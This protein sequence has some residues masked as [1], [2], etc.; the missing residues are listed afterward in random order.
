MSSQRKQSPNRRANP[1][2]CMWADATRIGSRSRA[3]YRRARPLDR[4]DCCFAFHSRKW[5]QAI[6]DA[7]TI[8]SQTRLRGSSARSVPKGRAICRPGRR[9]CRATRAVKPLTPHA[10]KR[11]CRAGYGR[12]L[13]RRRHIQEPM[14]F[15]T[16][17]QAIHM[18]ATSGAGGKS[19]TD[20]TS[21]QAVPPSW[22]PNHP[23]LFHRKWP[24]P[25]DRSLVD[26]FAS[27]DH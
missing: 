9:T 16:A 4:A 20:P 7:T 5:N 11:D 27:L 15:A 19:T 21:I 24:G 14:P 3:G 2:F 25:V 12:I 13:S 18:P 23:P 10:S 26:I 17:K 8:M 6:N 22:E 1:G